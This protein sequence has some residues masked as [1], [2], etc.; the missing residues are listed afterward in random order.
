MIF[1]RTMTSEKTSSQTESWFV[2]RTRFGQEIKIGKKLQS[3]GVEHFIPV[4]VRKNYRGQ[5]KEHPLIPCLVFIRAT[6]Q[7]ACELRTDYMLPV[8]YQFDHASHQMMTVPDKEM[9]DFRRVL[10]FSIQEGGLIGTEVVRGARIRVSKGPLAGV[11]G[12]V[13]ELQG[14]YYIVVSL[15]GLAFARAHIPRAYMEVLE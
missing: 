6:K 14:Q 3:L 10:D 11:E 13:L 4:E 15:A 7:C 2:A 8:N 12:Q 5:A 1:V 9:E